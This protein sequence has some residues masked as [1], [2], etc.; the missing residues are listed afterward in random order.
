MHDIYCEAFDIQK[1]KS[2]VYC[3]ISEVALSPLPCLNQ[4]SF[5]FPLLASQAICHPLNTPPTLSPGGGGKGGGKQKRA[6]VSDEKSSGEN[7]RT[8]SRRVRISRRPSHW[9]KSR[10]PLSLDRA[11][12]QQQWRGVEWRPPPPGLVSKFS[13]KHSQVYF[14]FRLKSNVFSLSTTKR[15]FKHKSSGRE[16]W[17]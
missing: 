4:I 7:Q 17:E 13:R 6:L 10:S 15:L 11:G 8:I 16:A 2:L 5:T 3:H 1:L 14:S 9:S 12:A